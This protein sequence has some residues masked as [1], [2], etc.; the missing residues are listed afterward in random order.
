MSKSPST[1]SATLPSSPKASLWSYL[2]SWIADNIRSPKSRRMLFRS[3]LASWAAFVLIL[4]QKSLNTM[5]NAAFFGFLASM[6]LPPAFPIQLFLIT[7]ST[8]LLGVLLG[9]GIGS[10]GMRFA[11]A[12]RSQVLLKADLQIADSSIAG[13]ANPDALF[14]AIIFEGQFLDSRSSIVFGVF[15]GIGSF[16]F[17]VMRAYSK[18]LIF[19]SIFGTIAIDIFCAI[20]P[21]FPFGDYLLLNNLLI[22]VSC[23]AAIGVVVI[24]V[25]FPET[26]N[27]AY[28][29]TVSVL[30]RKIEFM[31]A[32]QEDVL[33]T[34][35]D[36][37]KAQDDTVTKLGAARAA[38]FSI[39]QGLTLQSKFINLEFSFGKWNGDDALTLE[40]P[41]MGII[42]RINGLMS[43][44]KYVKRGVAA[45]VGPDTETSALAP[46]TQAQ[47]KDT[48]LLQQ[49]SQRNHQREKE[50]SLGIVDILPILKESTQELRD[51]AVGGIMAARSMLDFI[52][53][54]RWVWRNLRQ[55][56]PSAEEDE[57]L[58][59]ATE[60]L[61]TAMEDFKNTQRHR[62]LDPYMSHFTNAK[63]KEAQAA[64]PLRALY[65][66]YVFSATFI[67]VSEGVL[68]LMELVRDM[69]SKR[70][71][72][73]LWAPRG[74]RHLAHA[75]FLDKKE[76]VDGKA[77][78][79]G[80]SM[81]EVVPDPPEDEKSYRRDPDSLPPTNIVQKFMTL[82]HKGYKW[83]RTPEALF[84][85]RYVLIS[86]LLWLPAVF[87]ASAHF[88]YVNKGIWA[89]IMAQT[90][91]TI[92]IG[93][94]LYNYVI[95][96]AGTAIGLVY[97]LLIW[98]VGNARGN[99]TPYGE[100]ASVAVF[101][102]P[103]VFVRLFGPP[104]FLQGII[105]MNA[106]VVLIQGYSWIDGHLAVI[107]NPGIGWPVAW[108]R[109]TLVVIGSAASFILMILPAKSGRKTIRLH[110][111]RTI[112]GLSTVYSS[113]MSAWISDDD[114]VDGE[115]GPSEAS[116]AWVDS[117]R[118]KMLAVALQIQTVK[119]DAILAKWEGS[120][121]GHWPYEDY[122]RMLCLQEEMI[123][124]LS[125]LGGAL[126]KLDPTWRVSFIHHT[127][128]VNPNFI[129]EVLSVFSLV[130]QSLR[131][132]E[133]MHVVLPQNL[134][135]RLL[136]HH[137]AVFFI[138]DSEPQGLIN[139]EEIQ[140]FDYLFYA[141]AVISVVQLM[142]LLDELHNITRRLC[143]E[144][145]FKGFERWRDEHQ[146]AHAPTLV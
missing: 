58:D 92:F 48:Y 111:A 5:G 49:L 129:T 96:L 53:T 75:I 4:P 103:L 2:P 38:S 30:L 11:V 79:E 126:I 94:Q 52:N 66:S 119:E 87:K 56:K 16:I 101:V 140:S 145:P 83:T 41:L 21:L 132:G 67:S 117:F 72:N 47:S 68:V 42:S 88:Y 80:E 141:S 13:S 43:F 44:L 138:P 69:N 107:S 116:L 90:T 115:K 8:L 123:A 86:I 25:V 124:V 74:L 61:R 137:T 118:N 102:L 127:K 100:A 27:H 144:V 113:L 108:R 130:S 106:T 40:K 24:I 65:V 89:L 57:R 31:L 81:E 46:S 95:R 93:D 39:Y 59:I 63:T 64:L 62:L 36:N 109:W 23:Y 73:R 114:G 133:P 104:Q 29:A 146:R 139:L 22:P 12:V 71:V 91:L 15:L 50:L 112:T 14:K 1:S 34:K 120:I 143:G 84:I 19:T 28:L 20:G 125:L 78:G 135:D 7:I 122:N 60:R 9:W 54:N 33:S 51:A 142:E 136:Y 70:R 3:W 105:L 121:R 26:V 37:I 85:F 17:A 134:L 55:G 35:L 97:G 77:F 76:G 128:V 131:T 98:Y 10:A 6:F 99:G 45:T 18:P 32:A 110:T 82:L